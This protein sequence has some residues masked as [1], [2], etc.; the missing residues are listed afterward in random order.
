MSPADRSL[1]H[2]NPKNALNHMKPHILKLAVLC[3]ALVSNIVFAESP[4]EA[5][6]PGVQY[7]GVIELGSK[8]IKPIVVQPGGKD[9]KG[10]Q[11]LAKFVKKYAPVNKNPY[12]GEMAKNVAAEVV[13]IRELMQKD[14]NIPQERVFIVESSGIPEKVKTTLVHNLPDGTPIDFMDVARECRLVFR[15]IV[16]PRRMGLNQV[17]VLDIGSGN[18][19]GAYLTKNTPPLEY[20]TFSVPL[21]TALLAKTVN[22]KRK[23]GEA[24]LPVAMGVVAEQVLAPLR[25]Q[26]RAKPGMQNCNRIY[27]A[28][29]LPYVMTTFLHPERIGVKDKEDPT[30][31]KDSDWVELSPEDIS[32]FYTRATTDPTELLHPDL[33]TVKGITAENRPKAEKEIANASKIFNQDEITAGAILLKTFMDEMRVDRS[34]KIFFSR[35]ALYAWPQGYVTE[36]LAE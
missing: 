29:G 11:L 13:G 19:K 21:G 8:G 4:A 14:Y 30:G 35:A 28:G 2:T 18:S 6:A 34:K 27:L 15:G 7:Y 32:S 12:D 20:E 9:A 33:N 17:V 5:P 23:P 36:K 22:D 24:F 10:G 25:S 3:A 26:V 31:K 16:P 1:S